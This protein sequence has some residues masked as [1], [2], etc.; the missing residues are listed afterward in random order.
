MHDAQ[1]ERRFGGTSH[2]RFGIHCVVPGGPGAQTRCR[3]LRRHHQRAGRA[4]PDSLFGRMV[5]QPPHLA[6]CGSLVMPISMTVPVG[7]RHGGHRARILGRSMAGGNWSSR[8]R[9]AAL[10]GQRHESSPAVRW[11]RTTERPTAPNG[12][13]GA[14]SPA[15]DTARGSGL[16]S[17]GVDRRHNTRAQSALAAEEGNVAPPGSDDW[18]LTGRAAGECAG[19]F[20]PHD[21]A[22]ASSH[23]TH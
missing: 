3:L 1:I 17:K 8:I 13:R 4:L 5:E 18:T 10:C 7:F 2:D 12:G 23:S 20:D 6:Q 15:R 14:S 9:T 19:R 22:C 11:S 21:D 16:F